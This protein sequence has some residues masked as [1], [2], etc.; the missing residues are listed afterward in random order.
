MGN[1]KSRLAIDDNRGKQRFVGQKDAKPSTGKQTHIRDDDKK[2]A[3][4]EQNHIA[5]SIIRENVSGRVPTDDEIKVSLALQQ[6][7]VEG[8]LKKPDLIAIL[9]RLNPERDNALISQY[10]VQDLIDYIRHELYVVP[11]ESFANRQTL[12][13]EDESDEVSHEETNPFL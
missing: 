3:A 8:P 7:Q 12:M 5:R 1:K 13:I 4:R 10:K 11:L 9:I 2:P 6:I